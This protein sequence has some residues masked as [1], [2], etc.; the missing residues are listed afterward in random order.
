MRADFSLLWLRVWV[1]GGNLALL[2]RDKKDGKRGKLND[3]RKEG[4]SQNRFIVKQSHYRAADKPRDPISG[5]KQPKCRAAFLR[6]NDA[7]EHGLE[8]RTLRA[9]PDSPKDHPN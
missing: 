9:H 4:D 8:Q 3:D 7:C 6:R 1:H 2:V 5:I